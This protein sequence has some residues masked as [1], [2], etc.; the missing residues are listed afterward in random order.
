MTWNRQRTYAALVGIGIWVLLGKTIVMTL[1]GG[2]TTFVPWVAALLA[3][4]FAL[5]AGVFLSAIVWWCSATARFARLSLRLTAAT[6]IVHAVRVLIYVLSQAGPWH[7][8]DVRPE[9]RAAP[10]GEWIWVA[11]AATMSAISLVGL[12]IVW[13]RRR[14]R[15]EE[16]GH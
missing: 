15:A 1:G 13:R 5:N 4:E 2:L 14:H 12:V 8:F 3:L 7:G 16:P 6:V 10:G 9:H 11:F